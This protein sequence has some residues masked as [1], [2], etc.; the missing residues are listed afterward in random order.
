MAVSVGVGDS[1]SV[2]EAV[3]SGVSVGVDVSV[4]AAVGD[5]RSVGARVSVA[6]GIE[7][8]V[9][10]SCSVGVAVSSCPRLKE[11]GNAID[12]SSRP[13]KTS[14]IHTRVG[15]IKKGVM[16]S[17]PFVYKKRMKIM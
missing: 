6:V 8:A 15:R 4:H 7:G 16:R 11:V 3:G 17:P 10:G 5:G 2:G 14:D 12:A 9:G 13:M 1:V